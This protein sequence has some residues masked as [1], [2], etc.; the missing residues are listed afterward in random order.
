MFQGHM[1]AKGTYEELQ[2]SGVD[3]TSLLK[4][5]E[6]EEQLQQPP[7]EG[8]AR[9]RTLSENSVRSQTS[10]VHSVKDGDNLPVRIPPPAVARASRGQPIRTSV[11]SRQAE[12]VQTVPE[13]IRADGTIS[14]KLYLKYLRAGANVLLL[15]VV[16]LINLLAQVQTDRQPAGGAKE[17]LLLPLG[18]LTLCSVLQV[19]YVMQDWWLAYW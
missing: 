6:E 2:Q 16:M 12:Q 11:F 10:S 18:G 9:S 8:H 4:A 15:V 14:A 1:V 7:S 3:F 19:A 5:E 13:E 17:R